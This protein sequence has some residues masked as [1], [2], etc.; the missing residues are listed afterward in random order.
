MATFVDY[1]MTNHELAYTSSEDISHLYSDD[2]KTNHSQSGGGDD[3]NHPT[4]GFPPI[5][6]ISTKDAEEIE[7]SK[8]RELSTNT[9]KTTI[10]IKDILKSKK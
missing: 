6:I 3:K 10:S 9:N 7:K 8:N 5:Y 1:S 4:G 2:V